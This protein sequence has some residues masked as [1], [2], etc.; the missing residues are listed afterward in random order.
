MAWSIIVIILLA[1]ADQ[2]LKAVV[3]NNISPG[4]MRLLT[5]FSIWSTVIIRAR[6]ELSANKD[7]GYV[8]TVI[9][10]VVT[11][12]ALVII[13]RSRH[14][15]LQACLTL[16][17]GAILLI[18]SDIKALRIIWIF[19]WRL[20]LPTFNLA[21]MLIVCMILLALLILTDHD[22]VKGGWSV[23]RKGKAG[24]YPYENTHGSEDNH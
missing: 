13:F 5:D 9:S 7:W 19:I 10:A 8:L 12:S 15:R 17:P 2:L 1:S 20:Y 4:K 24:D 3:R 14:L 21:D 23:G 6:L 11:R 18:V 22:L 16:L